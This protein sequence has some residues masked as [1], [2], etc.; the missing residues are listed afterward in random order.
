MRMIFITF[1]SITIVLL[2]ELFSLAPVSVNHAMFIPLMI[3]GGTAILLATFFFNTL[4]LNSLAALE[5]GLVPNIMSLLIRDR[6]FYFS[7]MFLFIFPLLSY[8]FSI[9]TFQQVNHEKWVFFIWLILFGMSLDV[10]RGSWLRIVNFLTPSFLVK[11]ISQEAMKSIQKNADEALWYNIDS[12]SEIALSAV[13]KGKLALATQVLQT[14]PPILETFFESSKSIS[15]ENQDKQ[16]EQITGLDEAS[17]TVFYLLQRLELIN[18]KSLKNNLETLCRHMIMTMGKIVRDSAKFDLSM[19]SFPTH[20][21]SKFGLQAQQHHFNEVAI[22]TTSSLIEIAKTITLEIDLT[23]AEL[24]EPF[25]SI[26]NGLDALAK[27]TFKKDKSTNIDLLIQPFFEIKKMFETEKM[28]KHQD[29]PLVTK[30]LNQVIGE[31]Q[32][33]KEILN[34]TPSIS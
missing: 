4:I 21:L 3:S 10:I 17:Y 18:D 24:E 32:A 27:G 30:M 6:P 1:C 14:I 9:L 19:V 12:L 8:G 29:T 25:R 23:Y 16:V 11:H 33:L 34:G 31:F 7:R 28:A 15:R 26:I 22:L 20:L 13:E 2:L 5:H